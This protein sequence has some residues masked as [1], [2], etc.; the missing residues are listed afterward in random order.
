LGIRRRGSAT[1]RYD[2]DSFVDCVSV[3]FP[4]DTSILVRGFRGAG[5]GHFALDWSFPHDPV[6]R[7]A[8]GRV[9]EHLSASRSV[10][11]RGGCGHLGHERLRLDFGL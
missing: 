1:L 8:L 11:R 4:S 9:D 3:W 6:L 10:R 7:S 5:A 2:A